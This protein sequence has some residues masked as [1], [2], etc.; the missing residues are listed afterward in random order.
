MDYEKFIQPKEMEIGGQKFAVSKIPA[1]QA[2]AIYPAIAKSVK[3][4]GLLGLTMLPVDVVRSLMSFSAVKNGE[5][6][7]PLGN[8]E[9]LADT[10]KDNFGDM[11]KLLVS[12]EKYTY[13]FFVS[14]DLLDELAAAEATDSAS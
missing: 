7:M 10:F 12:I 4:N 8:D 14:G 2:Q 6:W 11:Q 13:D 5:H 9:V 1:I 3:E